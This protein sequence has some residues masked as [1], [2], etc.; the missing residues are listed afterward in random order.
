MAERS[1]AGWLARTA[2]VRLARCLAP[3][4]MAPALI[5]N[6]DW[7]ASSGW[8]PNVAA[9]FMIL[10]A[11][12]LIAAASHRP[13]WVWSP[14]WIAVA[15]FLVY[16]NTKQAVRALSVASEAASE[17]REARMLAGSQVASQRSR[18]EVRRAAQSKIAGEDAVATL[19]A[20]IELLKV[21]EPQRWRQTKE[22]DPVAVTSS[23]EFCK[24]VTEARAKVAAAIE[25]DK[26]DGELRTLPAATMVGEVVPRVADAYVANVISLLG[27]LGIKPTERLVAAE[28]AMSR[29]LGL[30]LVAAFA[31]ACWLIFLDLF[32]GVAPAAARLR[33]APKPKSDDAPAPAAREPTKADWFDRWFASDLELHEGAVMTSK[34][35]RATPGWPGDQPGVHEKMIWQRLRNLPRVKHDPNSGRPRYIGLRLRTKVAVLATVDGTRV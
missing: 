31:P 33:R 26:I 18:L 20:A 10:G 5:F 15:L 2:L 25:R 17:G 12:L 21:S 34:Q 27:E 7:T 11:A 28:E 4:W 8:G 29:A 19:E 35:L 14:I 13:H 22:C 9:V 3:F 23:T 1:T 6:I 32:S 16:G 24:R 30:E